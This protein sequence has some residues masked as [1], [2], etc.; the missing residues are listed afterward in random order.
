M[1]DSKELSFV[2]EVFVFKT[3]RMEQTTRR[4]LGGLVLV[5]LIYALGMRNNDALSSNVIPLKIQA[6]ILLKILAYDRNLSHRT[7]QEHN[8]IV[9][10]LICHQ[11][12]TA[13]KIRS[14]FA[15]Y[16]GKTLQMI[17]LK[18]EV[19]T[20]K[21]AAEFEQNIKKK[22]FAA[23]YLCEDFDGELIEE[24]SKH[25]KK[26][27][28]PLFSGNEDFVHHGAAVGLKLVDKRLKILIHISNAKNQG[29]DLPAK[30]IKLAE[31]I[32]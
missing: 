1:E 11:K 17:P 28:V 13:E 32:E 10:A 3:L 21:D 31:I 9:F 30:L 15:A 5:A 7:D 18:I 2:A 16:E 19:F 22:R 24:L 27:E 29:L 25:A 8:Q 26:Y 6:P 12:E 14:E 4:I 23:V 20:C